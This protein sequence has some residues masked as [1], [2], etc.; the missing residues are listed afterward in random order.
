MGERRQFDV[1][2]NVYDLVTANR[3]LDRMGLGAYHS[4]V[5][6]N[7]VE[8]FFG[9]GGG[10]GQTGEPRA[11]AFGAFKT[12]LEVGD[13]FGTVG[14]LRALVSELR[15]QFPAEV[16]WSAAIAVGPRHHRRR[17]RRR[18]RALNNDAV[19]ATHPPPHPCAHSSTPCR[20][21]CRPQPGLPPRA[22]QL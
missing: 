7:G 22:Q 4:G 5:E 17:R 11:S 15:G 6:V 2:V 21:P 16:G 12:A 20:H 1:R 9:E 13:F 3:W 8:Y 19:C 10:V 18:R 14:E